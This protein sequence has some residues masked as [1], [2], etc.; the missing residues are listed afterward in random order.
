QTAEAWMRIR[1][2]RLVLLIGDPG[3]PIR[4]LYEKRERALARLLRF[5]DALKEAEV[6][7]SR[8]D[9]QK[10]GARIVRLIGYKLAQ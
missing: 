9:A 1:P 8:Q 10:R 3:S 2:E 5:R 4:Q 7:F 6:Q